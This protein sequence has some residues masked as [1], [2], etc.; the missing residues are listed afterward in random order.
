MNRPVHVFDNGVRVYADILLPVQLQRYQTKN[1]HE[2]VEESWFTKTIAELNGADWVFADIGAAFGYYTILARKLSPALEIIAVEPSPRNLKLMGDMLQLNGLGMDGIRFE[3]VAVSSSRG[4]TA[5]VDD[6]VASRI[7]NA[8][9]QAKAIK[10]PIRT[11]P[12]LVG[13]TEK[14]LLVK[15]DVQGHELE[16]LA[17]ASPLFGKGREMRWIIGTHSPELHQQVLTWVNKRGGLVE[18]EAQKL[19]LEPDGL[20]VAKFS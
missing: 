14:R 9:E 8:Y 20:V 19:P 13:N 1:L 18:F 10:V 3:P 15:L 16:V 17:G 11:F 6:F 2:P 4:E 7:A 5:L 12:E